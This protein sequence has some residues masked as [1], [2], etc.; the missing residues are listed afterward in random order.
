LTCI[1]EEQINLINSVHMFYN[2]LL[3]LLTCQSV[4]LADSTIIQL[5]KETPETHLYKKRDVS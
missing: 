2:E 3:S 5:S 4:F 1:K